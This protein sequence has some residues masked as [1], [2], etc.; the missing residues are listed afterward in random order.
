MFFSSRFST[1]PPLHCAI[2]RSGSHLHFLTHYLEAVVDSIFEGED[3]EYYKSLECVD[4]VKSKCEDV[5]FVFE[6][7]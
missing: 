4:D 1:I 7:S 6:E 3:K 2:L 5:M